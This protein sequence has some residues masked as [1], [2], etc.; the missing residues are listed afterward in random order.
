MAFIPDIK[1]CSTCGES[2]FFYNVAMFQ[3]IMAR[4]LLGQ[5]SDL[6]I[7]LCLFHVSYMIYKRKRVFI[8]HISVHD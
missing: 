6:R 3:N 4:I 5:D 2:K 7:E 8:L 1:Y